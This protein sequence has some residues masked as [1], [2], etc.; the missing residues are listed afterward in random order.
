MMMAA[1][2][3]SPDGGGAG[4]G[5]G[6]S[7]ARYRVNVIVDHDGQ[8]GAPVIYEDHPSFP[9]LIGRIEHQ[10]R[11]GALVTDFTLIKPGALHRANGGYLIPR[12]PQAAARA[13][14][15]E[16]LKRVLRA[17]EVRIESL[18]QP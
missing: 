12:C 10:A 2:G 16:E 7:F 14:C 3:G 11:L 9:N 5:D 6:P 17:R 13:A 1:G 4:P 18:G 8:S 15:W